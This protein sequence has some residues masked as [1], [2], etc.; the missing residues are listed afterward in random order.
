MQVRHST[1]KPDWQECTLTPSASFQ[2][3]VDELFLHLKP[4]N[5]SSFRRP[6]IHLRIL[7]TDPDGLYLVLFMHHALYDGLSIPSLL[8]HVEHIYQDQEVARP[9]QFFDF[10]PY[11]LSQQDH[12]TAYWTQRL[13]NYRPVTLLRSTSLSSKG[14]VASRLVSVQQNFLVQLVHDSAITLQCLAQAA[15]AKYL[16]SLALSDDI[17]FGHVVSGR[18]FDDSEQVVGP[19]LVSGNHDIIGEDI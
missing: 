9:A 10:V 19:M 14:I 12:A 13:Q 7:R 4:T 18:L 15:W 3:T 8:S 17:V 2:H 1:V 5:E 11:I 6:P 16:A